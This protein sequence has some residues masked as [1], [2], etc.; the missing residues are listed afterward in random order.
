[1]SSELEP[2]TAQVIALEMTKYNLEGAE[3]FGE[4][5]YIFPPDESR[6]SVWT[7]QYRL[8]I[9][10]ALDKILE[11]D[12]AL[13]YVLLVG[14]ILPLA[15]LINILSSKY[16]AFKAL[17]FN[18]GSREYEAVLMNGANKDAGRN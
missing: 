2:K 1:M 15:I 7:N 18:A 16:R 10:H 6:P 4:L 11:F 5:M 9:E 17:V 14:Q 3:K 8:N 13:D 12:P